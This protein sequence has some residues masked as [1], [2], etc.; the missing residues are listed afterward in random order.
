MSDR[1]WQ[2]WGKEDPYYGVYSEDRFSRN[3]IRDHRDEFFAT[4]EK[5]VDVLLDRTI[6]YFGPVPTGRAL[7][8]GSGV[9]RMTIP[10][11]RRFNDVVGLDIS[12]DMIAEATE[13]CKK[14]DIS[15]ATFLISDDEL[16][17]VTGTFDLVLS[18]IVLQHVVPER[19]LP[20]IDRLLARVSTG[21]VAVLQASVKRPEISLPAK[22]RY[23]VRH[24]LPWI[25]ATLNVLRGKPWS[26]L[27]MRMSEYDPVGILRLY[28]KNGM[29]DVVVTEHYQGD[30]LT[31]H[32]MAKKLS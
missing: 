15:N 12:T 22:V 30:V 4:G 29:S 10:L 31:Y 2:Q 8:F 23:Y 27:S 24:E 25:R 5:M 21:G 1:Q 26:T 28:R 17:H 32:F 14:F 18:Y 19:G 11:A 9:G 3:Q 6:R 20:I 7:E 13:N 16:S